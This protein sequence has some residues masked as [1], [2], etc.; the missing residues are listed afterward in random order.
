[1]AR[2]RMEFLLDDTAFKNR[3]GGIIRQGKPT[4]RRRCATAWPPRRSWV[5]ART[6]RAAKQGHGDTT[7]GALPQRRCAPAWP[8]RRT[9]V[10]ARTARAAKQ[11]RASPHTRGAAHCL[12]APENLRLG[13]DSTGGQAGGGPA[14]TR[15]AAHCLA[16]RRPVAG[17]ALVAPA[18]GQAVAHRHGV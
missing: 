11:G 13:K 14:H 8:P 1:S 17:A 5:R 4:T 2:K 16:A 7:S 15:G 18:G 9:W 3:R 6:V 12:A 10:R